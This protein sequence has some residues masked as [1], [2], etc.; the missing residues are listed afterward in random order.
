MVDKDQVVLGDFKWFGQTLYVDLQV[1]CL[2][3]GLVM[4][5][6]IHTDHVAMRILDHVTNLEMMHLDQ[7]L[8]LHLHHVDFGKTIAFGHFD[9][10]CRVFATGG[11]S[12]GGL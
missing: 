10:D 3:V 5:K 11:C 2:D 6:A 1:G 8:V 9:N 4:T 12:C 7:P